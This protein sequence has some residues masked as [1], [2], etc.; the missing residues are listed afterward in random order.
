MMDAQTQRIDQFLLMHSVRPDQ[1]RDITH[2]A[3]ACAAGRAERAELEAALGGMEALEASSRLPRPG[4]RSGNCASASL[5]MMRP[6][7]LSLPD[8]SPTRS[9]PALIGSVRPDGASTT[10]WRRTKC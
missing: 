8:A 5:A 1:W 10:T 3:A 7:P 2:L 4:Y 6:A 9:S